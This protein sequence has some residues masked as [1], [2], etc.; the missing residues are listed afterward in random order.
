VEFRALVD[1]RGTS[2]VGR[3]WYL[4]RVRGR[5]YFPYGPK[6]RLRR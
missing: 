5:A 2:P 3:A 6:K 1:I 4:P